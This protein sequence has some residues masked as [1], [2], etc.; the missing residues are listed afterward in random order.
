MYNKEMDWF[1]RST[2]ISQK[3]SALFIILIAVALFA[4]LSYVV[5]NM[6]RSGSSGTNLNE[7]RAEIYASEA[8]DYARNIRQTVQD[9]RI[10]NGCKDTD[11]SFEATGLTGYE[12][13]PVA[14]DD[15]KV[16]HTSGGGMSYATPSADINDGVDWLFSGANQ[17]QSIGTDDQGSFSHDSLE[18]IAW[19]PYISLDLCNALNE[20][21]DIAS[22]PPVDQVSADYIKFTGSYSAS[23]EI[24]DS[25]NILEGKMAACF[26][27][28]DVF[29][30]PSNGGYHFYQVLIAR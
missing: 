30:G 6:M 29:G 16:F 21:L 3:G 1:F 4:A 20:Q 13:T 26:Q 10:S 7:E 28:A 17:I 24:L 2:H 22:P 8:L 15:C 11:I 25:G 23:N 5:S 19:L 12:H 18:I 9:L 14:T 27:A